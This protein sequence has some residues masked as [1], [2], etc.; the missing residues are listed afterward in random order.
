MR[1][2]KMFFGKKRGYNRFEKKI[3]KDVS[4]ENRLIKHELAV[5]EIAFARGYNS[6]TTAALPHWR[7]WKPQFLNKCRSEDEAYQAGIKFA[8]HW[9][10]RKEIIL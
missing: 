10:N 9:T 5:A 4:K 6:V 8:H 2:S 7:F 1:E 3:N